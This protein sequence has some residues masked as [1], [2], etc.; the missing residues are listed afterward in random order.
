MCK[1]LLGKYRTQRDLLQ[2]CLCYQSFSVEERTDPGMQRMR[3]GIPH[4]TT[5]QS[6][7]PLNFRGF[8]GASPVSDSAVLLLSSWS[9]PDAPLAFTTPLARSDKIVR[10]LPQQLFCTTNS[11]NTKYIHFTII[12]DCENQLMSIL[13]CEKRNPDSLVKCQLYLWLGIA[14][15]TLCHS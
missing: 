15:A 12:K 14:V 9:P 11:V 6:L 8:T 2:A 4:W 1:Q 10:K 7:P 3:G 5:A 13:E